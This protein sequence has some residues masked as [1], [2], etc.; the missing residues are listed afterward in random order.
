MVDFFYLIERLIYC[1]SVQVASY[2]GQ[3]RIAEFG[4]RNPQWVDG[5]LLQLNGKVTKLCKMCSAIS[6]FCKPEFQFKLSISL[7]GSLNFYNAGYWTICQRCRS[8]FPLC[9]P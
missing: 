5:E 6:S 3:G 8:R 7:V 9:H 1:S 2:K 4:F